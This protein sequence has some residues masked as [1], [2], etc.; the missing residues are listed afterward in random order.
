MKII[1][2]IALI[3]VTSLIVIMVLFNIYNFISVKILKQDLAHFNGYSILEVVSGSMEP[4][5]NVGDL[6]VIDTKESK[7]KENDIVTFYDVN[8]TFVTHRIVEINDK[9]MVTKG[10]NNKSLDESTKTDKIIG[11]YV[12]RIRGVGNFLNAL[13]NPLVSIMI[14]VVGIMICYFLSEN[15]NGKPVYADEEDED[16]KK[17][18]EEKREEEKKSKKEINLITKIKDFYE[19][20]LN[21]KKKR[22]NKKKGKGKKKN[23]NK[24]VSSNKVNKSSKTLK[25]DSKNEGTNK[26]S[27]KKPSEIKTKTSN[28]KSSGSPSNKKKTNQSN[29]TTTVK[30]KKATKTSKT[31]KEE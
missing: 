21:K 5:I 28:K 24:K 18:I 10:D 3:A 11:K 8:N 15:K 12:F 14:L 23:Q 20:K 30:E 9:T 13:K 26:K 22:K 31:K 2:K 4:T 25:K 7:Y 29:K 27:S 6:I 19:K 1:K 17:F 16:F